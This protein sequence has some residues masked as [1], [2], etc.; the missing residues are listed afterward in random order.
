MSA[1][2]PWPLDT[3]LSPTS[4]FYIDME[5]AAV[6]SVGPVGAARPVSYGMFPEDVTD[7]DQPITRSQ[8]AQWVRANS[9]TASRSEDA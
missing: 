3:S 1:A 8:P 2:Q 4:T 7:P 5:R 6:V 9:D